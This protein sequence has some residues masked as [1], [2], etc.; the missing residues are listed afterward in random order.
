[1][2]LFTALAT[3]CSIVPS[4]LSE[5]ESNAEDGT[6]GLCD[7]TKDCDTDAHCK[8][9]L[10]CADRHKPQLQALGLDMR[11]ANCPVLEGKPDKYELCFDAKVL[12]PSAGGGGGKCSNCP[13][14]RKWSR[15]CHGSLTLTFHFG[16]ILTSEPTMARCTV[17]M[18]NVI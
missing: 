13:I 14:P 3:I 6:V 10:L 1:M 4:V 11:S 7:I 5:S 2:K 8:P 12:S 17:S 15:I 9:G 16:K 18:D